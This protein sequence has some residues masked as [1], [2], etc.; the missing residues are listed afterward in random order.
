MYCQPPVTRRLM[1]SVI[2]RCVSRRFVVTSFFLVDGYA[3]SQSFCEFFGVA[4]V[5]VF[6]QLTK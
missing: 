5:N 2:G 1:P 4:T 6:C 3:Y